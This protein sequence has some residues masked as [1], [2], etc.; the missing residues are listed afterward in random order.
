[1]LAERISIFIRVAI[2]YGN[3]NNNKKTGLFSTIALVENRLSESRFNNALSLCNIVHYNVIKRSRAKNF[4]YYYHCC[5]CRGASKTRSEKWLFFSLFNCYM[6]PFLTQFYSSQ[7]IWR[8]SKFAKTKPLSLH[9]NSLEA[10]A[11]DRVA[12]LSREERQ[13]RRILPLTLVSRR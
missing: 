2:I 4:Y 13:H 7:A 9:S 11:E 8:S 10:I 12:F 6:A 1:M 5:Y 3:D